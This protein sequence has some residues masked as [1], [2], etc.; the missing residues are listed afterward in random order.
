MILDEQILSK[1]TIQILNEKKIIKEYRNSKPFPHLIIEN[2][3]DSEIANRISN[4]FPNYNEQY[5]HSYS[6][7]IEEKKVTN[8]W[9]KFPKDIYSHFYIFVLRVLPPY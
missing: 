1:G 2:F 8:D 5:L 3:L 7:A 6:N 9:N 4:L